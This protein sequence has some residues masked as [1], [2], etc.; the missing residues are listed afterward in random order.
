MKSKMTDVVELGQDDDWY[1]TP[2]VTMECDWC[3]TDLIRKREILKPASCD[4][5]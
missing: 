5:D 3:L 1:G 2:K 4:P